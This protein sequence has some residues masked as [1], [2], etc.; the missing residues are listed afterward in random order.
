MDTKRKRH[1]YSSD[2]DDEHQSKRLR[3]DRKHKREE[4]GS[5]SSPSKRPRISTT[6]EEYPHFGLRKRQRSSDDDTTTKLPKQKRQRTDDFLC[7]WRLNH[8]LKQLHLENI[9]VKMWRY[10]WQQADIPS[11]VERDV[12][13]EIYPIPHACH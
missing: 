13:G 5:E 3:L 4:E 11:S 7:S 1:A 2:D 10:A 6:N 12:L 8:L 9:L